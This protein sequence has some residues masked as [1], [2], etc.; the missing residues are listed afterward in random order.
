MVKQVLGVIGGLL[1]MAGTGMV[2]PVAMLWVLGIPLKNH[3]A[4]GA[5]LL[6]AGFTFIIAAS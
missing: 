1:V 6:V 3:L 5:S 2:F 4:L